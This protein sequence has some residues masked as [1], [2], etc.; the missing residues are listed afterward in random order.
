M[1]Q[2]KR[3]NLNLLSN[4]RN[5]IPKKRTYWICSDHKCNKLN[6]FQYLNIWRSSSCS[7]FSIFEHISSDFFHSFI[8]LFEFPKH[9]GDFLT[10][11]NFG[12]YPSYDNFP[13]K[14]INLNFDE[15]KGSSLHDHKLNMVHWSGAN[16]R[17]FLEAN[18]PIGFGKI[19]S[20]L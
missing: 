12:S 16:F 7:Y 15:A 1:S 3:T 13:R 9:C 6:R 20:Q 18:N 2:R 17:E 10:S 19:K 14:L 5:Q 4:R 8:P 11:K